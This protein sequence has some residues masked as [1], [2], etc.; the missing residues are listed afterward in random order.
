MTKPISLALIAA[1][2]AAMPLALS[3]AGAQMVTRVVTT[4]SD[5]RSGYG[6]GD[7][8]GYHNRGYRN[9]RH[10][11]TVWRHHQRVTRCY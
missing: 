1:S 3:A 5:H 7:H 4:H 9:N 6:R 10:C 11:K 8:R 2:L